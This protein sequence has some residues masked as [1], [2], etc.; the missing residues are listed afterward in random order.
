MSNTPGSPNFPP[1]ATSNFYSNYLNCLANSGVAPRQRKWYV[2]HIEQFIKTR[3]GRRI[4]SLSVSEIDSYLEML[5]RKKNMQSWYFLQHINAIQILYCDLFA[6][7]LGNEIDWDHWKASARQLGN[8]HPTTARQLT[9]DELTFTK[10]RNSTGPLQQVRTEHHDLL[11]RLVV[12]I[13]RRN[14]AYRTEQTY[15]QWVCRYILFCKG[16]SPVHTG[17]TEISAYLEYLVIQRG[18]G[19]S[20]QNQA[21]NALVFLYSKVLDRELGE[22]KNFIRAKRS[23]NLPVVLSRK[24]VAILL[25]AMNGIHKLLASLLYGTGMR[26]LELMRLRVLDIDFQYQR[27]V[28][29][30]AKGR[31]DRYVPLPDKLAGQLRKQIEAVKNLHLK[32]IAAGHGE[33]ILPGALHRKYSSAGHEL[34]WQ[35]VFPSKRLSI[36][37]HGGTIR[38]HHLHESTLQKAVKRAVTSCLINKRIGCHTLRH[39][40]ATHLLESGHDIRT[41]QVLLGHANVSTTMIYTHVL[42]RPGIS[43]FS[44]LDLLNDD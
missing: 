28:V 6:L 2:K 26:L 22:L 4:K 34:K 17:A 13:R 24:E 14:Y 25:R 16:Q 36:D 10:E 29:R 11:V 39:S 8:D 5:G 27:I 32:D 41:V 23:Q 9:P 38:R 20:S 37:P 1:D 19:P 30:Q 33:V 43:A 7:P 21:L 12:E 15:E 44:P 40:F 18:N 35:F 31:K 42:D 3:S